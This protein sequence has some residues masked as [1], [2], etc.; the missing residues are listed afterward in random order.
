M[1]V[2]LVTWDLNKEKPNYNQARQKL[3]N[4]LNQYEHIKDPGLDSVWFISSTSSAS[5]L[6]GSIRANMDDSD[7]LFVTKLVTGNH[8]GWIGQDI[9]T[10][11][12]ARI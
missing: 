2:Y 6:E 9:W 3:I 5:A 12:N 10:W 1:A 8:Q 11:I 4:H 7:R